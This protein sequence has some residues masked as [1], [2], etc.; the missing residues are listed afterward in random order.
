MRDTPDRRERSASLFGQ[1]SCRESG[2]QKM[3]EI[4]EEE[5]SSEP[6]VE[7]ATG[8]SLGLGRWTLH[9]HQSQKYKTNSIGESVKQS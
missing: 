7:N 4:D 6:L 3:R 8:E 9:T 5:L 1:Y 2:A